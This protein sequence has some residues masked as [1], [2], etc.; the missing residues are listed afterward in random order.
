MKKQKKGEKEVEVEISTEAKI[1][2]NK[3]NSIDIIGSKNIPDN[4]KK[5]SSNEDDFDEYEDD[6]EP[7]G[8]MEIEAKDSDLSKFYPGDA[9][10]IPDNHNDI[11]FEFDS[12]MNKKRELY[13]II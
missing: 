7:E 8:E 6:F 5:H 9:K 10:E 13:N 4:D 11:K 3:M 1:V 2:N 12:D